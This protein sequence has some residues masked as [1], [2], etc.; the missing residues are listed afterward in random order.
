MTEELKKQIKI[1]ARAGASEGEIAESRLSKLDDNSSR[2][3]TRHSEIP[4]F[5]YRY[6][7]I[8][9]VGTG[10][11]G[12]V[13]KVRDS[14]TDAIL[15]IK[16]L[17]STLQDD[18]TALKRFESECIALSRLTDPNL[19][20]IFDHGITPDGKPYLV[21]QY[22]EGETLASF[23][24]REKSMGPLQSID[25]FK[26]IC[27]A[28]AHAH[29][30]GIVHRDLKPS[31]IVVTHAEGS[32]V[33]I[34]VV[35]FGLSRI[36]ESATGK[37]SNITQSSDLFGTPAYMSPE[38]CQGK[39]CDH[40]CDIYSLGCIMY[41]VLTGSPPF[42]AE[43]PIQLAVKH[44]SKS[45]SQFPA[46]I[47]KQEMMDSLESITLRCL[48]KQAGDRF[49]SMD[50]LK[51]A[52]SDVS[53]G[54]RIA[55]G[56]RRATNHWWVWLDG[57]LRG[58]GSVPYQTSRFADWCSLSVVS[59]YLSLVYL[60]LGG[61]FDSLAIVTPLSNNLSA[62]QTFVWVNLV[63]VVSLPLL[64][65]RLF[66]MLE[67][68]EAEQ[69][70]LDGVLRLAVCSVLAITGVSLFAMYTMNLDLSSGAIGY[71]ASFL[72]LTFLFFLYLYILVPVVG[73]TVRVVLSFNAPPN[74]R[75]S[76]KFALVQYGIS[77]ALIVASCSI[78][79]VTSS[80]L[81][82]QTNA[83]LISDRA[84]MVSMALLEHGLI[85]LK[86]ARSRQDLS[87][88]KLLIALR[89]A[90]SKE[91]VLQALKSVPDTA[92]SAEDL[93]YKAKLYASFGEPELAL[94]ALDECAQRGLDYDKA[95]YLAQHA[96]INEK[97]GR[98]DH[99]IADYTKAL[100]QK[101]N[102]LESLHIGR[103]RAVL[104]AKFN[105]FK[106]AHADL[107]AAQWG[108]ID[109]CAVDLVTQSIVA[110]MA[111]EFQSA[112]RYLKDANHEP[113]CP[114]VIQLYIDTKLGVAPRESIKSLTVNPETTEKLNVELF[115]QHTR[116]PLSWQ[117]LPKK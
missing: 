40:R 94:K 26:Q 79:G 101:Q 50:E 63:G 117:P 114:D 86:D 43:Q 81:W 96:L 109:S 68:P 35:D 92:L 95:K 102:S 37:T 17:K 10:G 14:Q 9:V 4:N 21:M 47:A 75:P 31:N 78:F 39:N 64:T 25:L 115:D 13:Y 108:A 18:Q 89:S 77:A 112:R 83:A 56:V 93:S 52:L 97:L 61:A 105:N 41:E 3:E 34:K 84:P 54:P 73:G 45:P 44:V 38:Q 62:F 74:Q 30:K 85:G 113:S 48:E 1:S 110:E 82:Y 33:S 59:L 19:V 7:F 80:P 46:A 70:Y 87:G 91:E 67:G 5:G 69:I 20:S 71:L 53:S 27:E 55:S 104:E 98:F 51:R 100:Q 88:L 76:M 32:T 2:I 29:E 58:S 6:L 106:A 99:A 11:T 49:Q 23:L 16:V 36:I 24:A 116:L 107:K 72:A 60:L 66:K 22:V 65:Y 111:H 57:L 15:A 12:T 90:R 42:T 28:L 103:H 8:E